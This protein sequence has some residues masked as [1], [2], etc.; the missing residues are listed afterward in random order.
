[1]HVEGGGRGAGGGKIFIAR[2]I[3]SSICLFS[4]SS[5]KGPA[6]NKRTHALVTLLRNGTMAD[7]YHSNPC[8]T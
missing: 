2:Y 7:I 8:S 6:S 3:P 1:M 5:T 4:W